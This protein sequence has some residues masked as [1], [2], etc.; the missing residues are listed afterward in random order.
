MATEA[1]KIINNQDL[2]EKISQKATAFTAQY[3]WENVAAA[4]V[5]AYNNLF[6]K[7]NNPT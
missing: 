5:E 3:S 4:E 2:R 6:A 7:F 1:L